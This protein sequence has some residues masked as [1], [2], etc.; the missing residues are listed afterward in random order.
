MSYSFRSSPLLAI[1]VG[2]F[3]LLTTP[4]FASTLT[5]TTAGGNGQN[6]NMFEMVSA[7]AI[8]IDG[9]D[10]YLYSS[11][12][13]NWEV[14]TSSSAVTSI[15]TTA[16]AWTLVSSGTIT[17]GT[18]GT[19]Q[20]ITL[21][22]AVAMPAGTTTSWYITLTNGIV[23]Y[24]NGTAVGR[25]YAS[26]AD[27][28][29]REGYGKS[30]PFASSFSPRVWNGTVYY[31][32]SCTS[33]TWYADS[34]AD[35]YGASAS[36]TTSACTAPSG[37]VAVNTDCDDGD[38]DTFP[39]AASNDSATSCMN[40]DDGDN[41]GDDTVSGS[42]VAGS[43]CDDSA[44]TVRP[45]V[46][47][48]CDGI[49]ND[50]D[51][52][53]DEAEAVDAADF[54]Y[55][56]DGDTFGDASVGVTECYVSAGFVS[57]ATDCDDTDA[58][59]FPGVALIDS[60]TACMNDD[61][62]D[63][64]G[65]TSVTGSVVAGSDCDDV[66]AAINPAAAEICDVGSTDEDC[67]G[68]ADDADFS[69]FG[70]TTWY[71]D[72]DSDGYGDTRYTRA[73]CDQPSGYVADATDCADTIAAI[74][75]AATEICDSA[76]TDEDCDGDADDADASA[77]ASTKSTFYLD[78]DADAFGSTTAGAYCDLPGGY[79]TNATDCDDT[80]GAINP[81]ATEVCDASD[82]DE[83]CDGDADNDD[84]SA[85]R[86]TKTTYYLDEDTDGFGSSST[87]EY[88]D[89][90][91]G[92]VTN[93]SD[94]DDESD[95]VYPLAAEILAD[96]IDNDCD[97]TETCYADG[98]DDGYRTASTVSSSDGDCGDS[99]EALGTTPA[100]DC[101]D[102]TAAI[103]PAHAEGTGDG[104]DS[105]CDGVET[106]F[107]DADDDGYRPDA[108]SAIASADTDC[109][110]DGEALS[111]QPTGDCED[112]TDSIHPGATDVAGDTIDSDCDGTESCYVDADYDGARTEFV[113]VSTNISCSDLGEALGSAD[114]DCDDL[115]P[116][117]SPDATELLGT[118]VD[119]DCDGSEICYLDADDD[120][121]RPDAVSAVVSD[122][123][124]CA[125][126]AE[127]LA[128]DPTGDCD[129]TTTRYNPAASETDCSDPADYN[130]DG[131][132]GYADGDLDGWAACEECD[133]AVAEINPDAREIAGDGVDGDCDGVDVCYVDADDDGYRPDLTSMIAG[134]TIAC[135]GTGE[136]GVSEPDG[137]CDDTDA[138]VSPA[139]VEVAG[140]D[141]D[142]DCDGEEICY[143]DADGDTFRTEET[144]V[145][146]DDFCDASGEASGSAGEDCD[147]ADSAINPDAVEAPGDEVDA[148]CDNEEVCYA[149]ADD[150]AFRPDAT[151]TVV[152]ADSSCADS[153]EAIA[154]DAIDDCNDADASVNPDG[155]EVSGDEVDSDC[156]GLETCY[157]DA[158][159]D[160]YRPDDTSTVGSVD[161]DCSDA[162]E[163]LASDLVDD[164]DDG[165]A[166]F[167]PGATEDDCD[168][169]ND[170]NCDG[171]VGY[172]DADADGF[173]AC[174]ECN[175]GDAAIYPGA[176][177]TVGDA[178]DGDCDGLETCFA[179]ADDDGHRPDE[180]ST[181]S[182]A[183]VACDGVGEALATDPFDD[184]DDDNAAVNSEATEVAGDEV[185]GDCDGTEYCYLDGD[186]DGYRPDG[187]GV[188]ASTDVLC[189]GA[190]G[191]ATD[192]AQE[193]DC[194]DTK[195][196][197]YPGA[198]ETDCEDPADYNC[199]GSSGYADV[200][201]DTFAACEE[202][203]DAVGTVNPDA[204]EVCNDIDDDCDGTIDGATSADAHTWYVD[205]DSD[206]YTDAERSVTDCAQ[207]EFYVDPSDESDCDDVNN[208]V[209]P[210]ATE[211][212]DDGID[213]DCDGSDLQSDITG[214]GDGD[215][216]DDGDKE[217]TAG[218]CGCGSSG[219][220]G[221]LLGL[222]VP[223]L[224][225]IRRRRRG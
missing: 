167:H 125:D 208:T 207:P 150:D 185:D 77:D 197:F 219:E 143:V 156:D 14:Y 195:P 94:C 124:D 21:S 79:V 2:L 56:D 163:A 224:L 92:F 154:T 51:A 131:S 127:A 69:A 63:N 181:V 104:V 140:D 90:P 144:V 204:T 108:T 172:V 223:A 73:L 105:N 184:C 141:F 134:T 157:T 58:D 54:Y 209:H 174:E 47:E 87:G 210:D 166:A 121:Y 25:T 11:G 202:C 103:H 168:D 99:G 217:A 88:C 206:G 123:S 68:T 120:G 114:L 155:I 180:T 70:E 193:G 164:C 162:G 13:Y 160:E 199:D 135:D 115:D 4:A 170:Y 106:C 196:A 119:E 146:V 158:D 29:I 218:A 46:D 221:S 6:G 118:G 173:A 76:D 148:D 152:S 67:D 201:R 28:A 186:A 44:S 3:G 145:S 86:S 27:L 26:N 138:W 39:G 81:A 1:T 80:A 112:T 37:Y 16:S 111:V 220:P 192:D 78:D 176:V 5:T 188:V 41:Y 198:S 52:T 75:P 64:Y 182:T 24:T 133:D 101:D 161:D 116:T 222:L 9:F 183:N 50:C 100:E 55:D 66:V 203:D 175:D 97:G 32:A 19:A 122:D 147:D 200:D 225:L 61:D 7:T 194:D 109:T 187:G 178:I 42:V 38:A 15:T 72:Y 136:A 45:G 153:G 95:A 34:D 177:D 137:D 53:I 96:G 191:E 110:D 132:T 151:S 89:V 36:G 84:S 30:Y 85:A 215:V 10:V 71:I 18:A 169:P 205:A 65:D 17:G 43:D 91:S 128:S 212:M 40:D 213:Q 31:S 165:N 189:E 57:D 142:Q 82:T 48:Y 129:D 179:D 117:S 60:A 190:A 216:V 159:D 149:D 102:S 22:S 171:S 98:D 211:V 214:N 74:N 33:S 62:G 8:Q 20:H 107:V 35:G 59:T 83:D 12:T 130:C 93:A 139:A 126:A 113:V 23:Q 49:D